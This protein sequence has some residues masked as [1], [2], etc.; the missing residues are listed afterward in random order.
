MSV[1]VC[2]KKTKSDQYIKNG[3]L[4]ICFKPGRFSG[5][6]SDLSV[7]SRVF[8]AGGALRS[9]NTDL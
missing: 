5:G 2:G 1:C 6:L 7:F 9:E 8:S 4:R 3:V